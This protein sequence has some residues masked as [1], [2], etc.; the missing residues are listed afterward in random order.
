MDDCEQVLGGSLI[1]RNTRWWLVDSSAPAA[2]S[3]P[4]HGGFC[5]GNKG[6]W[7]KKLHMF[8]RAECAFLGS[9]VRSCWRTTRQSCPQSCA[10][11]FIFA[12][13]VHESSERAR[14]LALESAA[15]INHNY[16]L[17]SCR[18]SL[19]GRG[20]LQAVAQNATWR[21]NGGDC[22]TDASRRTQRG[23]FNWRFP[24]P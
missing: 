13:E 9:S 24:A 3:A 12:W 16:Q 11:C 20:H 7:K 14:A 4:Q 10:Y 23:G 21:Q 8:S 18:C 19:A 22:D 17:D 5:L 15:I 1:F 6:P 2:S